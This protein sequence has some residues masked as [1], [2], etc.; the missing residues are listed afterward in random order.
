MVRGKEGGR[1]GEREGGRERD[2]SR[3][4]KDENVLL[5]IDLEPDPKL[6]T[7]ILHVLIHARGAEAV[8]DPLVL[9]P[10]VVLVPLPVRH[11]QVHRLVLFV[12]GPGPAHARQ[13]VERD[14]AVGFR[15]VDLRARGRRLRRGVVARLA[16]L[17][18]P[19]RLAAEE[20]GF[21]AGVE[22]AA[23]EAEGRVE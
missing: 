18:R 14:P 23:V 8:L 16:V 19:G 13:D 6:F 17:E 9:G 21:E 5:R 12:V 22:D 15:V 2:K 1:E 10:L 3:G 4:E 20:V 11:L 7:R